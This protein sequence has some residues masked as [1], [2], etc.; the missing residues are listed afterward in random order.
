[1]IARTGPEITLSAQA[2]FMTIDSMGPEVNP[3]WRYTDHE[4]HDH[5]GNDL[6]ATMREI[7]VER[8]DADD[9]ETWEAHDHWECKTCGEHIKPGVWYPG[10]RQVETGRTYTATIRHEGTVAVYRIDRQ[11]ADQIANGLDSTPD[12]IKAAIEANGQLT[13]ISH[14]A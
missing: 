8:Y 9:D 4:G 7:T 13:S 12:S 5:A 6:Q 14:Q 10:P 2:E 3:A 11:L 1:M